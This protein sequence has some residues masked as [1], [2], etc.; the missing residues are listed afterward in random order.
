[1]KIGTDPAQGVAIAQAL[2]EA[3][4]DRGCRVAITTHYMEL[5]QLASSDSRFAVAG[6]YRHCNVNFAV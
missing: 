1:M 5:K 2:L 4:L 6:E 3:L